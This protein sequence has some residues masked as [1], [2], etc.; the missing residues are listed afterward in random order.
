MSL[1][2]YEV[3]KPDAMDVCE[4]YGLPAWRFDELIRD[5]ETIVIKELEDAVIDSLETKQIKINSAAVT[6]KCFDLPQNTLEEIVMIPR[7]SQFVDKA[8]SRNVMAVAKDLLPEEDYRLLLMHPHVDENKGLPTNTPDHIDP[9]KTEREVRPEDI[10]N[11]M[12]NHL[13]DMAFFAFL[14]HL[15]ERNGNF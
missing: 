10:E 9:S 13:E 6:E 2:T 1:F 14:A 12:A 15:K 3:V 5:L 4:R 7:I 8:I 11:S